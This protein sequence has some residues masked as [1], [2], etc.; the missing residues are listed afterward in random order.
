MKMILSISGFVLI[1]F[2]FI[3]CNKGKDSTQPIQI[4]LIEK[5][6]TSS[7]EENTTDLSDI[8]RPSD[9]KVFPLSRFRQ[10]YIFYDQDSCKYLV[11]SPTDAHYWQTGI[12]DY[13]DNTRIVKIM[14]RDSTVVQ[15]F[16]IIELQNDLLKISSE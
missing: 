4:Q 15:E 8:Y 9:Y 16:K 14:N 7:Y 3:G 11:L 13:E 10:V 12:W 1:T 2:W 5:S 6:W